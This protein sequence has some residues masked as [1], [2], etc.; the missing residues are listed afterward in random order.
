MLCRECL[1]HTRV[2]IVA[3]SLSSTV[4]CWKVLMSIYSEC[5]KPGHRQNSGPRVDPQHAYIIYYV[6]ACILTLSEIS[7]CMHV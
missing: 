4:L 6:M 7:T 2:D 5:G 1:T 3:S